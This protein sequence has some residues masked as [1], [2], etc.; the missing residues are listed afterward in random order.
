MLRSLEQKRAKYAWE[1]I[2]KVRGN[3]E[4]EDKYKSYVRSAPSYIQ[5]NGLGNTLAFYKSKFEADL[6][7]K[8]E[9]ELSAD[10]RAYKLLY[11]HLNGWRKELRGGKDILEWIR[12]ENT[13]SL[14]VFQATKEIIALLNWMKRFAEAELRDK[15]E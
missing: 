11:D 4:Q 9:N 10:K 15:E 14:M 3:I 8:G 12:D 7:K 5:I 2:Q 13:S 6:R 1:C